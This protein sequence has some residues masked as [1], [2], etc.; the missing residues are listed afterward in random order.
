MDVTDIQIGRNA[1]TLNL[2]GNVQSSLVLDIGCGLGELCTY[3]KNY[4]GC[5]INRRNLDM[6]MKK[7]QQVKPQFQAADVFHLPYKDHVFDLV[8]FLEVMEHLPSNEANAIKEIRRVLKSSGYLILSTP[9]RGLYMW[10]DPGY[11]LTGHRHYGQAQLTKLLESFGFV[12]EEMV[13]AGGIVSCINFALHGL[14]T[15]VLRKRE[16]EVFIPQFLR[17]GGSKEYRNYRKNGRT[18]FIKARVAG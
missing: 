14:Q 3:F 13:T 4:V 6:A 9:N 5:D 8:L 2:V 11:W 15:K 18:I 7:Y 12:L 17:V 1:V 16:T 10:L